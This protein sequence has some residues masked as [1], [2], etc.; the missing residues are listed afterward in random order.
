MILFFDGAAGAARDFQEAAVDVMFY[1]VFDEEKDCLRRLL[2]RK[3]KAGY[4]ARTVQSH[5]AKTPPAPLVSTR[6]QS[7]IPESWA[8]LLDG[9]LTR[10]T[11]YDHLADAAVPCGSLPEYCSRAVAEQAILMTLAL[12]RKLPTQ[13]RNFENFRR[14]GMTG[15]E[16]RGAR[17]LVVGVG[18]I[19]RRAVALGRGLG[20]DVRGVDLEK[21]ERDLKYLPL[22]TGLSWADAVVCALP[23]TTRTKGML[24]YRSLRKVRPG[25]VFVNV[26]RGEVSPMAD[27]ARL[28][29]E[30]RLG[31]AGLDVFED[32][33]RVAECL[34][35]NIKKSHPSIAA[36]ARLQKLDNVILTPHN[37]FNTRESVERKSAETVKAVTTFLKT[38]RFLLP[39][40]GG[41][42][43]S[44]QE[45]LC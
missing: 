23:L 24:G 42:R 33:D 21:R 6:T 41:R 7:R 26:G 32:E 39:V 10:S 29:Q 8:P 19:G 43:P 22:G 16:L 36:L 11:G 35:G 5:C 14:E 34:R 1:E 31:G 15:R 17:L 38:G 9:I 2:P 28:L 20:M 40:P 12:F 4:T 44:S 13:T 27:L 37:A 3:I 25:A 30:R 18:R 45:E